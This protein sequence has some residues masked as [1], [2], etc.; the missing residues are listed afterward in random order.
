[1]PAAAD[2]EEPNRGSGP[3]LAPASDGPPGG[4][5][6]LRVLE[7]GSRPGLL[8]NI[9]GGVTGFFLGS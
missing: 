1:V 7:P 2:R 9:V 3:A 8:E 4:A 6:G 5:H